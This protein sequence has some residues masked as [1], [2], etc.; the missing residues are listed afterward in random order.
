MACRGPHVLLGKLAYRGAPRFVHMEEEEEVDAVLNTVMESGRI[1]QG[2]KGLQRTL[3]EDEVR[4]HTRVG[5]PTGLR[6]QSSP[7]LCGSLR[8]KANGKG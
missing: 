8:S 1:K 5:T 7:R 6:L 4:R 2:C 3:P